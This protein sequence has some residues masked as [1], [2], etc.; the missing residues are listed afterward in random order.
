MNDLL[1]HQQN[2]AANQRKYDTMS[3]DEKLTLL[4]ET[5]DAL[6]YA[7]PDGPAKHREAHE[8]WIKAKSAEEKF[9]SDLQLKLATEG[10]IGIVVILTGLIMLGL[11]YK[12]GF[13]H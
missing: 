11:A 9:W 8:S 6:A 1:E 3:V 5:V 4:L 12:F 10:I 13:T 7:F 2:I